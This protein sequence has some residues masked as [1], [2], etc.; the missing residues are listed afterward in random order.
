MYHPSQYFALTTPIAAKQG[1]GI[2]RNI[3]G[4]RVRTATVTYT[5]RANADLAY[6]CAGNMGI[7][8]FASRTASPQDTPLPNPVR[9]G[10]TFSC[11]MTVEA[12]R[13]DEGW[14]VRPVQGDPIAYPRT[15][16]RITA[17]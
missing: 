17:F 10:G 8:L 16:T 5:F 14:N 9:A 1:D 13:V 15:T 12:E 4:T 7:V 3:L 6:S 2:T 11:P